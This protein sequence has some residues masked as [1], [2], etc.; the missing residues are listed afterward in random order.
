M[1]DVIVIGAGGG[2][3]VVAKELASR[4]LDVLLLEAGPDYTHPE[5]D[6][7]HFEVDANDHFFGY[8][9]FGPADR[10]KRPWV[11][12]L[13]QNSVIQQVAGVGGT[14]LHYFGN[15]P[16][17]NPGNF[18]DYS[19]PDQDSYDAAHR[20]PFGYREMIPYY[21][22][23]EHTLPV[24]TAPMGTK[25][26]IF[27]RGAE[28]LGYPVQTTKDTDGPAFRPQENAI[29]QPEGTAGTSSDLFVLRYPRAKGCTFCGHCMQGCIEPLGA[30]RNLKAKRSTDNSYIPMALTADRW[31]G[32]RPITLVANAYATKI[33]TESDSRRVTWR[34]G[35]SGAFV[36]EDCKV[37][38]M[39]A[40]TIETPRLWL[41]SGLPNPNDQVGRGLTEHF[42]D[43]LGGITPFYTGTSKGA[44]SNARIDFPA[45]GAIEQFCGTPGFTAGSSILSD[46]GMAGYYDNGLPGDAHGAD[47]VG[48]VVGN[49]LKELMRDIDRILIL[50]IMTDDDVESQNR[51]MLSTNLPADEHGQ[52]PRVEVHQR[53]R[54]ARTVRNREF[55][56]G[57]GVEILRAAGASKVYRFNFPP[58]MI[59]LQSTMR[60]GTNVED[61]VVD[62]NGEARWGKGIFI[63]DN[64]V[65]AN[66]V[67]GM[68]PTLTTQA[69][70]T[71]TAERIFRLYFHGDSW[72]HR[73]AAI[74]STADS[75]TEAIMDLSGVGA[76]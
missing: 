15:S 13:P 29:L 40:G 21:E 36:T 39:A 31:S 14:T 62:E 74:C 57:K 20:F 24:R 58:T 25:E 16:R 69:L 8:F 5:K 70:A 42:S 7:N 34:D 68:N 63:A 22:W 65:L 48:R 37:I 4:G 51:V 49:P 41:N 50:V 17:A 9:R 59:H 75:V 19:R 72:V 54:S 26:E 46:A 23:V 43:A 2:G 32:G 64:S 11:R 52:V 44:G 76:L 73:E 30:P 1:R 27:F 3:A 33:A 47:S 38:V 28:R 60:M 45:F 53:Q 61:S 66:S 10:S 71:R 67:G 35:I 55:L 6:L 56:A 12:E 18:V